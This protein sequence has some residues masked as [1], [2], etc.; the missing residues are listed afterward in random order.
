MI[1]AH[2]GLRRRPFPVSPDHACY[3][4][5]TSHEQALAR[6]LDGLTDGE[7]L[8]ATDSR[9]ALAAQRDAPD[10]E[11]LTERFIE[12]KLATEAV[13]RGVTVLAF[14]AQE[15]TVERHAAMT[16][17][18]GIGPTSI[19]PWRMALASKDIWSGPSRSHDLYRIGLCCM[20]NRAAAELEVL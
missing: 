5:A 15:I 7:G 6:L 20:R 9:Y 18:I 13:R 1:E 17:A 10:L 19:A 14:E 12:G 4:P 3:Y 2:F 8:L 16:R 11:L